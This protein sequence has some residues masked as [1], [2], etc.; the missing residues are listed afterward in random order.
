LYNLLIIGQYFRE[1]PKMERSEWLKKVRSMA[2]TLYDHG[3]SSYWSKYG[4]EVEPLHRQFIDKFLGQLKGPGTILDAACGAGLYDG[5]LLEAGHTVLGIDQ[6]A[7]MLNRA[8][9][10]YPK[11]QFPNLHY[12]KLGLQ[13]MDFQSVFDGAICMDA[14]EHICPEDWPGIL[15]GFNQALKP[16][17]PLYITVDAM[18]ADEYRQSYERAIAMGLPVVY[19]EQ[20]DDLDAAYSIA[21]QQNP[22]D[23]NALSGERL[24]HTVYHFHPTMEQVR[25]WYAQ[26]GFAIEEEAV[27]TGYM[28]EYMHVLARKKS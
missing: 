15:A 21:M 16:G 19:G 13:E 10:H 26:A 22:L 23:P 8:R 14:M 27:G 18:L 17:G 5:I 11:E 3:A 24:D 6:S 9:E 7:G 12:L 2:E 1:V 4:K 25:T 20:V 28:E